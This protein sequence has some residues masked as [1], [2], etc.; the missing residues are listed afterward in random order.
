[1]IPDLRW[2][3]VV[4]LSPK[5]EAAVVALL[6]RRLMGRCEV[7]I[8][9]EEGSPAVIRN[10]PIL[11]DGT[12]MPTLFWLVD[13]ALRKAVATLEATGGVR[14]AER[15]VDAAALEG[16]H[17]RYEALR[18]A[19][20]GPDHQGPRPSGGVA[21]TRQGVK[22]LHAHYAWHLAGGDDPVGRWV[23]DHLAPTP[24]VGD[25]V[26][27]IDCG[28]NSTRLLIGDG[29]GSTVERLMTVTRLGEG[30]DASGRLAPEAIDRTLAVLSRYRSVLD[31]HGVTRVRVTATS[32]A[33]DATNREEFFEAALATV[34]VAPELLGGE[35][36]ARLS[37]MGAARELDEA[38]G[39]FL[40]V[41]IGGG[42]TEM[43]LG[44]GPARPP[45]GVVSIDMG[46]VRMTE[47]HLNGDPPA[48]EELT[49][50]LWAARDELELAA[51]RVAGLADA[52]TFVGLAGTVSTA[53]AVDL[54]LATYDRSQVHHHV[55]TRDAVEDVFRTLATESRSQRRHNPGLEPARV[56]VIVGG[57]VILV[58][59]MRHFAFDSCLVSESDILDGLVMSVAAGH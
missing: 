46:C 24:P 37:F 40:V 31:A 33:R 28:T 5:D 26:A 4:D 10:H 25:L 58:A 21:G 39:P 47:R 59:I 36:E 2:S 14:A 29:R 18:S 22:C 45:D 50:A 51:Q 52:R 16:S 15:D 17:R 57:M 12:P 1:M 9:T 34:G 44:A 19:A 55:L 53:A 56:D 32:A 43:A 27:A 41:D 7:V 49:N 42:S 8:R 6:G 13:P 20:L 3:P 35:E 48:P 54:G 38:D 23:A 30:V 11:N